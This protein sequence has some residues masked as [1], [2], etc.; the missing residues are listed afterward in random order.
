M[1]ADS[2]DWPYAARQYNGAGLNSYH[3]QIAILKSLPIQFGAGT[4][5][6]AAT[7]GAAESGN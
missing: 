6:Q 7:G 2:C 3:Y 5:A 4:Q 1:A